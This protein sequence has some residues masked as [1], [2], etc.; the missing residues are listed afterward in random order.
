MAAL[1]TKSDSGVS[2]VSFTVETTMLPSF[3]ARAAARFVNLGGF[4]V[5]A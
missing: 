1:A 5:L 3:A 4:I 2:A